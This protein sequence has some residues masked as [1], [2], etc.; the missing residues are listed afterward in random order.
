MSNRL[1]PQTRLCSLCK[2]LQFG[3]SY[4][5]VDEAPYKRQDVY[6]ELPELTASADSGC[7]FCLILKELILD[8]IP[9]MRHAKDESLVG[10]MRSVALAPKRFDIRTEKIRLAA[11]ENRRQN[12]AL[13]LHHFSVDLCATEKYPDHAGATPETLGGFDMRFDVFADPGKK[14]LWFWSRNR[15]V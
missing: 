2:V 9:R 13:G 1:L 7:G 6:P 4:S 11:Q 10:Q 14:A 3:G 15:G 12:G 8:E 5:S